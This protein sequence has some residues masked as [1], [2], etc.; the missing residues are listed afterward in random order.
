MSD[1]RWFNVVLDEVEGALL[2][3]YLKTRGIYYE[4]SSFGNFIHYEIDCTL[5]QANHIE[6]YISGFE[7]A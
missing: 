6:S 5:T 2:V 7:N 3:N 4:A 1:K